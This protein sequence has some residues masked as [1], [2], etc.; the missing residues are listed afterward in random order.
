MKKPP[1]T[2]SAKRSKSTRQ[3]PGTAS[4][5]P[6]ASGASTGALAGEAKNRS[7]PNSVSPIDPNGTSPI[8]TCLPDNRSQSIEPRPIPT[9]KIASS[10]VTNVSSPP[11]TFL[12]KTGNCARNSAPYSQNH[13]M[14]R[15]DRNTVRLWRAKPM[16]RH[17]SDSGFRL[18][19]SS[20]IG[21]GASG[22]PRLA[23]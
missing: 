6:S 10:N 12:A 15:I 18:T 1:N 3:T 14:P 23:R 4:R 13:E 17:V 9:V 7:M 5:L 21:A 8:S 19:L 22:M 16:L 11:S 20:G 2:P